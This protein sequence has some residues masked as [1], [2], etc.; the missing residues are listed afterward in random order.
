[1]K[2]EL[3]QPNRVPRYADSVTCYVTP[4]NVTPGVTLHARAVPDQVSGTYAVS[5]PLLL[6]PW[7][8]TRRATT[9]F[10]PRETAGPEGSA[11]AGP[12]ERGRNQPAGKPKPPAAEPPKPKARGL[13]QG[14]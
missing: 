7:P 9:L 10:E 4:R 3:G 8:G 6:E 13:P 1:M 2:Q 14:D 5:R 11:E 12:R